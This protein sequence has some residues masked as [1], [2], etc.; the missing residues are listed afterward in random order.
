[1]NR[2]PADD[3][4]DFIGNLWPAGDLP[5]GCGVVGGWQ[6]TGGVTCALCWGW[7]DCS[8][9][10]LGD[11]WLFGLD[12]LSGKK[13]LGGICRLSSGCFVRAE[14]TALSST[15][16]IS[17]MSEMFSKVTSLL[18]VVS[19]S[20]CVPVKPRLVSACSRVSVGLCPLSY[21]PVQVGLPV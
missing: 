15:P 21:E 5:D 4:G 7:R 17:N 10:H 12:V 9:A 3:L 19:C 18:D 16:N 2:E 6:E 20:S 13:P 14:T 11:V 1:M 8:A